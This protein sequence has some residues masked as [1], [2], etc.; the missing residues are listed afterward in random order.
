MKPKTKA[1]KVPSG[2]KYLMACDEGLVIA[3]KPRLVEIKNLKS[4]FLNSWFWFTHIAQGGVGFRMT[5][6]STGRCVPGCYDSR[7]D[8]RSFGIEKLTKAGQRQVVASIA[9]CKKIQ[10]NKPIRRVS[11]A[12]K[13]GGV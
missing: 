13:R 12:R 8:A 5:E 4:N 11:P 7:A 9:S 1:G 6:M 2:W 10:P 3:S